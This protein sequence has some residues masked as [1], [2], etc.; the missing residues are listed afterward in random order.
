MKRKRSLTERLLRILLG[1]WGSYSQWNDEDLVRARTAASIPHVESALREIQKETRQF[2]FRALKELGVATPKYRPPIDLYPRSRVDLLEV[3]SRP[4]RDAAK[5]LERGGTPEQAVA[6]FEKRLDGIVEA[7]V[8]IA[9]RDEL[10]RIQDQL[11][12]D[13]LT[14]YSK[15]EDA[16]L[17]DDDNAT[18][19]M[20]RQEMEEWID[21]FEDDYGREGEPVVNGERVIGWRRVIRPELSR[22]GTCG[23][24]V[25]AATQ[26]YTR[27]DLQAIHHLCK[28][29]TLPVTKSM[30]PGLRW[31]AEDLRRNLDEIYGAGGG[32]SGKKLKRIRVAVREHGELGPMLAYSAKRGWQPVE[33]FEPYTPPNAAVQKDRLNGRRSELEATLANLRDRLDGAGDRSGIDHAIWEIEQ[34]LKELDV[35]LA[36]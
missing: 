17:H 1:L 26:W 30:D 27:G 15:D 11:E 29:A 5:V 18:E 4:A 13:G 32:T 34:S 35:R 21:R 23:L 16:T 8:I 2:Q 36:A 3:Y 33:G 7:D 31:N 25:V 14:E 10:R 12:A 19:L 28:C 6:A 22:H 9:D 24:C 20:S